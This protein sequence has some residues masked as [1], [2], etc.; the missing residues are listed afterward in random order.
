M[1]VW[2]FIGHMLCYMPSLG[3]SNTITFH[4]HI[5]DQ[6]D[7]PKIRVW[8]TIGWIVA[9]FFVGFM[10]WSAKLTEYLLVTRLQSVQH[11]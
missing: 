6:N 5:P 2:M 10:G 7:F 1:M 9:G 4:S 8:G 11:L 3:L